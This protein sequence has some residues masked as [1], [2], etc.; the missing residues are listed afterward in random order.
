MIRIFLV[1]LALLASTTAVAGIGTVRNP[2]EST[3][4][5]YRLFPCEAEIAIQFPNTLLTDSIALAVLGD[6]NDFVLH[7][8]VP[9]ELSCLTFTVERAWSPDYAIP[10]DIRWI[11]LGIV[12]GLCNVLETVP[13][14]YIDRGSEAISN[15]VLQYRLAVRLT[16]GEQLYSYSEIL[17]LS[18]PDRLEITGMYPQPATDAVTVSMLLASPDA[19]QVRLFDTAGRLMTSLPQ[20]LLQAGLHPV[21][22]NVSSLPTGLYFFELRTADATTRQLLR[23]TR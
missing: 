5:T 10:S 6:V 8:S 1:S 3:E 23:V 20:Q 13:Y 17:L 2:V 7:W 11:E 16:G 19:V 15:G 14:S 21:T 4:T 18:T 12:P 9:P 22:I